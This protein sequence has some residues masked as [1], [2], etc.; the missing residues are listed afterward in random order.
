MTPNES[1]R[2]RLAEEIV[3]ICMT[4]CMAGFRENSAEYHPTVLEGLGHL[5]RDTSKDLKDH[6]IK[7]KPIYIRDLGNRLECLL[8]T[9][10]KTIGLSMTD[11]IKEQS[12]GHWQQMIAEN[13]GPGHVV[14]KIEGLSPGAKAI[15][16]SI[17][18]KEIAKLFLDEHP[19]VS[20]NVGEDLT[21]LILEVMTLA[22]APYRD[23]LGKIRE[24]VERNMKTGV[25]E[26]SEEL[27]EFTTKML[28]E[29]IY[30]SQFEPWAIPERLPTEAEKG[31]SKS[32]EITLERCVR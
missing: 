20:L 12:N 19:E 25:T 24:V 3:N 15:F 16:D 18:P 21:V 23:R 26:S 4:D 13:L 8:V 27:Q 1:R 11:R 14:G 29:M 32:T 28:C 5:F 7:S 6:G 31:K 17:T 30:V 9:Y 22:A 10:C 2:L